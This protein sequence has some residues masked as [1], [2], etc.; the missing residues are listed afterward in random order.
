MGRRAMAA[1]ADVSR[2]DAV[3]EMVRTVEAELGPVDILV[4]NA[5]IARPRRSRKSPR[6]IGMSCW[7]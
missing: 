4:N 5:G 3:R 7:R 6:M 1:G 2:G